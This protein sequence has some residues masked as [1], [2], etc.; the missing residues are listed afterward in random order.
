[1]CPIAPV[2]NLQ[3][4]LWHVNSNHECPRQC[5]RIRWTA[6]THHLDAFQLNN[7]CLYCPPKDRRNPCDTHVSI[8]CPVSNPKGTETLTF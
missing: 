4:L 1:M 8:A 6:C 7:E 5:S 3:G 2:I